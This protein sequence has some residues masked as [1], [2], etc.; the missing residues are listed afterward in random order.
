MRSEGRT[1][2]REIRAGSS[3]LSQ[4]SPW[5]TFGL[6]NAEQAEFL[7]VRWPD[8]STDQLENIQAGQTV[9]I[10]QGR[11]LR[12]IDAAQSGA[13]FDPGRD[14]EGLFIEILDNNQALVAMFTYAPGGNGLAWLLGIGQVDGSRVV[15]E[16]MLAFRGPQF[17]DD[18]DPGK[19]EQVSVGRLEMDFQVCDSRTVP[20]QFRFESNGAE[21]FENLQVRLTRLSQPVACDAAMPTQAS[22]T[23][24]GTFYDPER[25][26]EGIFLEILPDNR[27][28]ITWYTFD[29]LGNPFWVLADG[30]VNGDIIEATA[31]YPV[32]T[33]AF[34]AAFDN[35]EVELTEWGAIRLEFSS[36]DTLRLDYAAIEPFGSGSLAYQRLTSI[37][38]TR[39][40]D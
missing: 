20:G 30:T 8:G 28:L 5:P 2:S 1:Q 31:L 6:G 27:A 26:G 18:F 23:R 22:T 36:C 15:I 12:H 19:L 35:N 10:E 32:N 29:E 9:V 14:G 4:H 40:S 39:C 37:A 7:Q 25:N 34:G 33:T 16:E 11:G 21:G 24:S 38:N 13:Y 17:G 3:H